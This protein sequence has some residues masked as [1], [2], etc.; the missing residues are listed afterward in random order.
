MTPLNPFARFF[1]D[2]IF[3]I[4]SQRALEFR[5]IR[6]S[7]VSIEYTKLCGQNV[8]LI[9]TQD[10]YN[11]LVMLHKFIVFLFDETLKLI[12]HII[13]PELCQVKEHYSRANTVVIFYAK[14]LSSAD[15]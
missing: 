14:T 10:I 13:F 4:C 9:A 7:F 15:V 12:K 11:R 2:T 8:H 1:F 5:Y 3:I 6:C